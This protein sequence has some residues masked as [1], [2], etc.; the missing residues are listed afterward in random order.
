MTT[1]QILSRRSIKG[2]LNLGNTCYNNSAVQC[3]SNIAELTE[4]LLTGGW[5]SQVNPTNPIGSKGEILIEYIRLL[6]DLW[7]EDLQK[8]V[9][10]REFNRMISK[11]N[12]NV[13]LVCNLVRR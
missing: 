9:R 6:Q 8:C 12:K 1:D 5:E 11:Y 2:L 10:G 7:K 13:G 3:I 4:F